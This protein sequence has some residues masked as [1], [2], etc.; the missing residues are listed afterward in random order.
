MT[1]TTAPQ[2]GTNRFGERHWEWSDRD[3][4]NVVTID[5]E[6]YQGAAAS[7]QAFFDAGGMLASP[8]QCREIAAVLLA[9][10]DEREGK[11]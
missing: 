5:E 10:A 9:L 1:A 8:G 7:I 4:V 6:T 2:P 11:S 3:G